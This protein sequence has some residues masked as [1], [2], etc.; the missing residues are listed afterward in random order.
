MRQLVWVA[1]V[2]VYM[3]AAPFLRL[4]LWVLGWALALAAL[5]AWGLTA[6]GEGSAWWRVLLFAF[7][8]GACHWMRSALPRRL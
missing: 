5:G 4:G 8:S 1:L 3:F 6:G 7:A 2:P